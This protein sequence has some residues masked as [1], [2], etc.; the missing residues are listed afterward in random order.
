MEKQMTIHEALSTLKL[1][2]KRIQ[3]KLGNAFISK[4]LVANNK[5][6]DIDVKDYETKLKANFDS[7]KALIKNKAK[8]KA[9]I[10]KSNSITEVTI[11]KYTMTVQ[12]AIVR[13]HL[14]EDEEN[15]LAYLK[16][17]YSE[18]VKAMNKANEGLQEKAERYLVS[19]TQTDKT[20]RSAED[21]AELKE[22][23]IKGNTTVL[24]DPNNLGDVITAMEEDINTFISNVDF[25]LSKSNSLTV[26]KI[27][28]DEVAE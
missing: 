10:D 27:N 1:L 4:R 7:V 2:D 18:A 11:G 24:C 14:I 3:S 19:I 5:I 16:S 20:N 13:K 17:Q 8:I 26:I 28:L 21:L 22:S 23:Y 6:N 12:E 9:A 25:E 15:F